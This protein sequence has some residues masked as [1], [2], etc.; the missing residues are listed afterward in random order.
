[1]D[2]KAFRTGLR[3]KFRVSDLNFEIFILYLDFI[4]VIRFILDYVR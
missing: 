4:L 2:F 3:I 1:M